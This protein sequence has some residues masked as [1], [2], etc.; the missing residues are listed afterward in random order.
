MHSLTVAFAVP[1]QVTEK[2]EVE[3][4][5]VPGRTSIGPNE[6]EAGV[7]LQLCACAGPIPRSLQRVRFPQRA[8]KKTA[9]HRRI[10]PRAVLTLAPRP[11][12]LRG[13]IVSRTTAPEYAIKEAA[14]RARTNRRNAT[15]SVG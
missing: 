9:S 5:L 6:P 10:G 3:S 11:L 1:L 14:G 12:P 8:T 2:D 13:S 7:I 4:T 15:H